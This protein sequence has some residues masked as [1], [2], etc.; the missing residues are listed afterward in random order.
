MREARSSP[1]TT[2]PPSC[3]SASGRALRRGT[4]E[5]SFR[6]RS[7]WRLAAAQERSGPRSVSA[8]A[9]WS[10]QVSAL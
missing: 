10:Q 1:P 8:E 3:W 9:V 7:G 6:R 5:A 4:P 2:P